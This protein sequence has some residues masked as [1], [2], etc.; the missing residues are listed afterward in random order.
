[1][2]GT[3]SGWVILVLLSPPTLFVMEWLGRKVPPPGRAAP[4]TGR[5]EK[6]RISR[7]LSLLVRMLVLLTIFFGSVIVVG[8][9]RKA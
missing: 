7:A 3:V 9:V 8:L 2:P 4:Q 1:L 5:H 6:T